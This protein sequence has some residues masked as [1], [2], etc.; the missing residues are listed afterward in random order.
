ME[1]ENGNWQ[2]YEKLV[3][4]ELNRLSSEI[5]SLTKEITNLKVQA[6]KQGAVWGAIV[7]IAA[8]VLDRVFRSHN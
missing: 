8:L 1:S 4:H 3:I 7:S 5:K 2:K 6:S